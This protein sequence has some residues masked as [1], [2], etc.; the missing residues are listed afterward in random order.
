[1]S[2]ESW[3]GQVGRLDEEEISK[4]LA[5]AHLDRL[6]CLDDEGWPYVVPC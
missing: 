4:F 2:D 3:R 5:E 1:M 6:A